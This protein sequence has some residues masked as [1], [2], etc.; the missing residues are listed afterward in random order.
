MAA[1]L[2][3]PTLLTPKA[4][5]ESFTT[6]V[7]LDDGTYMQAQL[8]I[9]NA[10]FGNARGACRLLVIRPARKPQT[11][12]AVVDRDGWHYD[13]DPAPTLSVGGCQLAATA[14]SLTF[15]SSLDGA[16]VELLLQRPPKPMT[17]PDSPITV[18]SR[19]YTYEVLIPWA[20]AQVRLSGAGESPR[21]L[22][23]RGF[24]DHS[25]STTLPNE[26]AQGWLLFR[27]LGG[28]CLTLM[29]LRL[30]PGQKK[31]RGWLWRGGELP[32]PIAGEITLPAEDVHLPNK[33]ALD[34][35]EA[36]LEID[37]ST[38][39]NRHAPAEEFGVLGRVV[40]AWAGR[41]VTFTYRATAT[42]LAEC[43]AVPG[44]LEIT[45]VD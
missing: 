22:F 40:G 31:A 44:I 3:E 26:L 4:Y 12:T 45:H 21:P 33:L 10:G 9:T 1:R 19:A 30:P 16:A 28:A 35:E 8:A 34:F 11:A 13:A 2:L 18:G 23:G 42:G 6:I 7:D 17:P 25:R 5:A 27:A 15:F 36:H 41:V 14:D 24:A 43:G 39:L 32:D 29:Q 38:A 37:V 20:T